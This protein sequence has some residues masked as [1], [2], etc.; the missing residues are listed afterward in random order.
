MEHLRALVAEGLISEASGSTAG[1]VGRR[2]L[3]GAVAAGPVAIGLW[4]VAASAPSQAASID[5]AVV[6]PRYYS[7]GCDA[8]RNGEYTPFI[9]VDQAGQPVDLVITPTGETTATATGTVTLRLDDITSKY[10][11]VASYQIVPNT[12]RTDLLAN[13]VNLSMRKPHLDGVMGNEPSESF[14]APISDGLGSVTVDQQEI[15]PIGT[16]VTATITT[17]STSFAQNDPKAA[18]WAT[19]PFA[20][21]FS[22]GT[23]LPEPGPLADYADPEVYLFSERVVLGFTATYYDAAGTV[24]ASGSVAYQSFNE[25]SLP[26]DGSGDDPYVDARGKT[27]DWRPTQ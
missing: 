5:G 15:V 8:I 25:T 26:Y 7:V 2:A 4:S 21:A 14:Y 23:Y 18:D 9:S 10:P 27:Y 22:L 1:P 19:D 16:P 20:N 24:L 11:E 3:I 12:T 6:E 13:R 17:P